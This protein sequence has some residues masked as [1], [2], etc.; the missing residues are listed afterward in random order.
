M[1]KKNA[2]KHISKD[3]IPSKILRWYL[4]L[5]LAPMKRHAQ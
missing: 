4:L 1:K 3:E 5:I 2:S